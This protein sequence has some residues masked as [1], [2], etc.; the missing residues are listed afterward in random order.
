MAT[1][2]IWKL[3]V[4][5]QQQGVNGVNVFFWEQIGD[6]NNPNGD[7]QS[8]FDAFVDDV[9]DPWVAWLSDRVTFLGI[10]IQKWVP[11]AILPTI[12]P[13]SAITGTI[14]AD[15]IQSTKAALM[16][17]Y[18]TEATARGRGRSFFHGGSRN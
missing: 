10:R 15:P 17:T 9:I 18:T 4:V 1:G 2:D 7:T 12:I 8:V 16:A 5:T 3:D 14:D 6:T 13:F 11:K